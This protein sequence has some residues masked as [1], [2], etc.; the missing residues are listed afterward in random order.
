MDRATA[1]LA[2]GP[3]SISCVGSGIVT[4]RAC[5]GCLQLDEWVPSGVID[6]KSGSHS[7][8]VPRSPVRTLVRVSTGVIQM[9]SEHPR[10]GATFVMM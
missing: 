8:S 1:L 7:A 10:L 6:S 2:V 4:G 9:L 5:L 3:G